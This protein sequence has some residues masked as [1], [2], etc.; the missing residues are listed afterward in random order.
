VVRSLITNSAA[1]AG[2]SDST[3]RGGSL[4]GRLQPRSVVGRQLLG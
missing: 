2:P 3:V 4:N 1:L